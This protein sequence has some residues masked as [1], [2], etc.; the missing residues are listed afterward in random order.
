MRHIIPP[1]KQIEI[2]SLIFRI[3]GD[4]YEIYIKHLVLVILLILMRL[5]GI[6][7]YQHIAS[8]DPKGHNSILP[9]GPDLSGLHSQH[10][11]QELSNKAE[12][13]LIKGG[14]VDDYS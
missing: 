12:K 2:G 1:L 7:I 4:I 9:K 11:R 5:K 6:I 8:N 13:F 3:Y 14:I 10:N